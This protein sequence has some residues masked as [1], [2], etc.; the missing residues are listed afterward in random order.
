MY[1]LHSEC[2]FLSMLKIIFLFLLCVFLIVHDHFLLMNHLFNVTS[3]CI[4]PQDTGS[5]ITGCNIAKEWHC[6][7]VSNDQSTFPQCP[8]KHTVSDLLA[9]SFHRCLFSHVFVSR[10]CCRSPADW[11]LQGQTKG[12]GFQL[13][14]TTDTH[15]SRLIN[16]YEVLAFTLPAI[17][18][19]KLGLWVIMWTFTMLMTWTYKHHYK[20]INT[21]INVKIE[22]IFPGI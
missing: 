19:I 22:Y 15:V 18:G 5:L 16:L 9:N 4:W 17:W 2:S 14:F 12:F 21:I 13:C 7:Q 10:S 8:L 6:L 1:S 3:Y 20:N 11:H